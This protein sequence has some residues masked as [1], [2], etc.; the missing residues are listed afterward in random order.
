MSNYTEALNRQ[1]ATRD[2]AIQFLSNLSVTTVSSVK[3]Q[4][5][6]MKELTSSPS[7]LTLEAVVSWNKYDANSCEI[8]K[9]SIPFYF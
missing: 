5:T 1:A 6:A 2:Y 7:E 3:V 9:C 8:D 4:A